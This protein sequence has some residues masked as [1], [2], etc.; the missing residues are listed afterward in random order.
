M[1][2]T[3]ERILTVTLLLSISL[4]L[5]GLV[6]DAQATVV[7]LTEGL[8]IKVGFPGAVSG[9]DVEQGDS[10]DIMLLEPIIIDDSTIVEQGAMGKAVVEEAKGNGM[11]GKAG[12][13]RVK[14]A[15]MMPKGAFQSK[16]N[17][18]IMIS[19]E[20]ED[21]GNGKKTLSYALTIFIVGAFIKGGE[22]E[23]APNVPYDAKIAKSII[24]ESQ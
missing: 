8:E 17:Q 16:D 15:Y 7:R 11:F 10:V 19:G 2:P 4:A 21:I 24:L 13:V 14:F 3:V 9:N 20:A 12:M 22:G 5:P 18:P 23:L 1:R 6:S